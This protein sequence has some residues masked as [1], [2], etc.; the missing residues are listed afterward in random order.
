M[1]KN[2]KYQNVY[3]PLLQDD[4]LWEGDPKHLEVLKKPVLFRDYI[5]RPEVLSVM[6]SV[7]LA[8]T[9]SLVSIQDYSGQ[10]Q[11]T[12]SGY[13]IA[14][15]R[16][17]RGLFNLVRAPSEEA[18]KNFFL[19]DKADDDDQEPLVFTPNMSVTDLQAFQ[20][21]GSYT[22]GNAV[23]F[24][25]ASG[26]MGKALELEEPVPRIAPATVE[27]SFYFPLVPD[28][29]F[30]NVLSA[31]WEHDGQVDIDAVFFGRRHG[32][33]N[34]IV[35]EAK[36]GNRPGDSLSKLKLHYPLLAASI[37]LRGKARVSNP[38]PSFIEGVIPLYLRSWTDD[39]GVPF[40]RFCECETEA[41]IPDM[42]N[43]PA[44]SS[45][46]VVRRSTYRVPVAGRT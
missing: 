12:P 46:K 29:A 22:E 2:M 9:A 40:F 34:L 21:L 30:K 37:G 15:V 3:L 17:G 13:Y 27:S 28:P 19:F 33:M 6:G 23:Q 8:K 26:L 43:P 31:Y 5:K 16:M 36:Q 18:I 25:L 38:L 20:F 24:A 4:S 7:S 32:K 41:G 1:A 35:C 44:L 42:N 39:D 45:L 14:T 11:V 10:K